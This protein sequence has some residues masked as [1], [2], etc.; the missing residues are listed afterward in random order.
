MTRILVFAFAFL[1]IVPTPSLAQA[2]RV[3]RQFRHGG[4]QRSYLHYTPTGRARRKI[5]TLV[6]LHGGSGNG[7]K[8]ANQTGYDRLA[9][10]EGF[11]VL[12][13][14]GING[15]W[16]DG[17]SRRG[18]RGIDDVGFIRALIRR[19]VERHC[20]DPD[21]I[22]LTGISNG[23]MMALR[24][25]LE[26]TSEV[27][28]TAVVVANLP[29]ALANRTTGGA[30]PPLL[31]MNGTADP[32]IPW[33]G[34]GVGFYGRAGAVLSTHETIRFWTTRNRG[35]RVPVY[36]SDHLPDVDRNDT[37]TVERGR[38]LNLRAPVVL[39]T[40]HGGGHNFPGTQS[41]PSRRQQTG[42][43]NGDIN[44]PEIVWSFLSEHRRASPPG[45][46][47]R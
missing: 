43:Q 13:P 34:G 3:E 24:L 47:R 10:R 38:V 11:Q 17:R 8:V 9:A 32:I 31:V 30:L 29:A 15:H 25:S 37:S 42:P 22:Y 4:V 28:A 1:V 19:A 14:N 45:Q 33:G 20:A 7:E 16:N 39:Y 40:I 41:R 27:A 44:G 23:G 12:Y 35:P 46:P 26:L 2:S 6:V 36:R 5:P 21:R 18:T